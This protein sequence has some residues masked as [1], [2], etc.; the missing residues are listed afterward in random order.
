[1]AR[2]EA[3][4]LIFWSVPAIIAC[5]AGV[6]AWR[7]FRE[8]EWAPPRDQPELALL[9]PCA[10]GRYRCRAGKVEMTTGDRAPDGGPN[11]CAWME[12]ATCAKSCVTERATI[13]GVE[14]AVAKSQ[15]C[16]LPKRPLLLLS[17]TVSFLDSPIAE[18]GICEGDGYV[19]TEEGFLQCI[20]R[21]AKDPTATG[22]VIARSICRAG[23][24]KTV[25]RAPRL[26]SREE[27]AALWCKRDPIADT[28]PEDAGVSTD[29]DADAD[30][31][32]KADAK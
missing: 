24:I 30:A 5:V 31:Y 25:D 13:A 18:A 10:R 17:S 20:M 16:D 11:A 19:P 27:A 22:V 1:V 3:K 9:E 2:V 6:F 26:I 7:A 29:A 28:E 4:D 8:P 23:T 12:L 32:V 21:N 14:D 15:L